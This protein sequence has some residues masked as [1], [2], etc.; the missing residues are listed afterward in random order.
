MAAER[1]LA[2]GREIAGPPAIGRRRGKDRLGVADRGRQPLHGLG[3]GQIVE[4]YHPGRI[5]ACAVLGEGGDP[6]NLHLAVS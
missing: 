1:Y 5:S 3:Q 4:Q 6:L 2:F